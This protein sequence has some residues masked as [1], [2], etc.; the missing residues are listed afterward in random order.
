M[1]DHPDFAYINEA[2]EKI[3]VVMF[4]LRSPSALMAISF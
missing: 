3:Q 1:D 4:S 2:L